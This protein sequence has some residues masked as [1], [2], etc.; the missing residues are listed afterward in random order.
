[1]TTELSALTLLLITTTA[2]Y[3]VVSWQLIIEWINMPI[4]A[5]SIEAFIYL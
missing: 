5:L 4:A 2:L 1:M 3:S